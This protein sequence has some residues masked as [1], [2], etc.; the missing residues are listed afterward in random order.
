MKKTFCVVA[1]IANKSHTLVQA[2]FRRFQWRHASSKR[3][4]YDKAQKFREYETALKLMVGGSLCL[5][6]GWVRELKHWRCTSSRG[7]ELKKSLLPHSQ[8]LRVSREFFS[9]VLTSDLHLYICLI[10]IKNKLMEV[11]LEK[12]VTTCEWFCN[13]K[14]FRER[15]ISWNCDDQWASHSL[16]MKDPDI[17]C[18]G[19]SR[20]MC[21]TTNLKRCGS[22]PNIGIFHC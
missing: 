4:I 13:I 1:C 3:I 21:I 15:L 10:Q 20:T 18:E 11:D 22:G 14:W 19:L 5:F 12:R 16:D 6:G 8:E 7:A 9:R 2:N 17:Y